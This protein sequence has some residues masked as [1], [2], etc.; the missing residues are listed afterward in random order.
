LVRKRKQKR[1]GNCT[2]RADFESF[3]KNCWAERVQ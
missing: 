1:D 2:Y 3:G